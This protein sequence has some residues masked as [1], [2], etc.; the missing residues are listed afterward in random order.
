MEKTMIQLILLTGFLGAG[1]TT[2]MTSLL[3]AYQDRKVGVIINEF[4]TINIDA[5]L[6]EKEGIQM[7]EL[8]N[9][10]IFCACIKDKFVDSLIAMA[11]TDIEYLFIEASGLAD[12]SNMPQILS[13]ISHKTEDAYEYRGTLC[14][15]DGESFLDLMDLLPV[16]ERQVEYAEA[17]V[18]NKADLVDEEQIHAVSQKIGELNPAAQILVTSYC[19]LDIPSLFE[20]VHPLPKEERD[21]LNTVASRPASFILKA[22]AVLPQED[23]LA[24]LQQIAGDSYRIKGFLHTEQGEMEVSCVG[25]HI[26][27]HPWT[28]EPQADVLVIISAV[29]IKMLSLITQ[30]LGPNL[31]DKLGF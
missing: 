31:K 18:I 27:I 22:K 28:G 20:Q 1:K 26:Q 30:A 3:S 23:L 12:P 29:G 15:V 7:S 5:R 14:I 24:F 13:G 17:V 25:R 16:L 19:R 21:S 10:S 6:V 9:G 2:L 11:H 8:S 4:G